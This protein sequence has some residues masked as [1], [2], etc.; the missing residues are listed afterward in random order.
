MVF[1]DSVD[2]D[3]TAQKLQSDLKHSSRM[4]QPT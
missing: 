4:F 1:V 2:Q 3:Q